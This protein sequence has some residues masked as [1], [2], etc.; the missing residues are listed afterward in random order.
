MTQSEQRRIQKSGRSSFVITLPMDWV[1]SNKLKVG[2]LLTIE[3]ASDGTLK[4]RTL[5]IKEPKESVYKIKIE[6]ADDVNRI[7]P[8]IIACFV[9]GFDRI[10]IT[11][12]K[13]LS[14]SD[15]KE[16]KRVTEKT[17]IKC[18]G[19]GI[20]SESDSQIIIKSFVDSTKSVIFEGIYNR[21]TERVKKILKNS[22]LHFYSGEYICT[23]ED[24]E[25]LEN[26][27]NKI[28][29]QLMREIFVLLSDNGTLNETGK[30]NY[31]QLT[32]LRLFAKYLEEIA[33]HGLRLCEINQNL[34]KDG[35]IK[36]YK[37][38]LVKI[39]EQL[40]ITYEELIKNFP[41]VKIKDTW[42]NTEVITV[43][44]NHHKTLMSEVS[45]EKNGKIR[46]YT[47]LHYELDQIIN[48]LKT[49]NEISLTYNIVAGQMGSNSE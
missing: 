7:E 2:D 3:R 49:I 23:A 24:C 21:I 13:V 44:Q 41:N 6:S 1:T 39:G 42:K 22:T 11:W 43:L 17:L 12:N 46:Q 47:Q 15:L 34:S 31:K 32:E 40:I 19:M 29:N 4:I 10:E 37:T 16:L 18:T 26:D 5:E 8:I 48:L 27:I 20:I 28:Y 38:L 9:A 35:F 36:K 33:E 45:Q 25:T 14:L 30:M